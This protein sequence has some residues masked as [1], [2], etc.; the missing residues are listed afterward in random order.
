MD[1]DDPRPGRALADLRMRKTRAGL[2]KQRG[3]L[4]LSTPDVPPVNESIDQT[5][6]STRM[7]VV[8]TAGRARRFSLDAVDGPAERATPALS[9]SRGLLSGLRRDLS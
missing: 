9:S 3:L 1:G 2:L 8:V 5:A 4:Y 6:A 7:K